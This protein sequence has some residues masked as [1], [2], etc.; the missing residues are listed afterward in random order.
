MRKHYFLAAA[1]L[2]LGFTVW[3]SRPAAEA[4]PS[5]GP[6]T[7][8]AR[9][10]AGAAPGAN[11]DIITDFTPK[12][13][14]IL[15][16]TVS[17]TTSSVLNLVYTDGTTEYADGLNGNTALTAGALY[18]FEVDAPASDQG[19][20]ALTYNFQV[21]TDSVIRCLYVREVPR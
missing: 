5:N 18:T 21:E 10:H 12:S 2:L 9:I 4:A 3:T 20:D 7:Q 6:T 1:A 8:R 13:D 11:T 19:G 14:A 17:L 16:V 15:E